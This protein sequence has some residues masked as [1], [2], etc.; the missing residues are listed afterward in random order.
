MSYSVRDSGYGSPSM[1]QMTPGVKWLL[2]TN[3]AVFV[4]YFL[5]TV[6]G[7]AASNA[8]AFGHAFGERV[9]SIRELRPDGKETIIPGVD[10]GFAYRTC[11]AAAEGVILDV[12]LRVADRPDD[13]AEL[14]GFRAKRI[15]PAGLR[16]CGSV[17]RNPPGDAA[18]RLLEAAGAKA[19]AVGGARVWE[20]H[21]NVIVAGPD[22]R[23]SDILALARLMAAAVR[24]QF[25]IELVP[26]IRG[27]DVKG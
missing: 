1:F 19:L 10:C 20:R 13:P 25:G 27:L 18:G 23:S 4:L 14:D 21:A 8:G 17:F 2:I 22:A 12:R 6:G 9:E 3:I 11:R 24:E 26:E 7:W 16:T 5:A 15:H